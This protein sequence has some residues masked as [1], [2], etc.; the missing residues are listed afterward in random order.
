MNHTILP[1]F[2]TKVANRKRADVKTRLL[3][4]WR[5]QNMFWTERHQH[6]NHLTTTICKDKIWTGFCLKTPGFKIS[7]GLELRSL[8]T[9]G[10]NKKKLISIS[11][12][13]H[14]LN[15]TASIIITL[16]TKLRAPAVTMH[17][18]IYLFCTHIHKESLEKLANHETYLQF[19]TGYS[20]LINRLSA[21]HLR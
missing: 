9:V 4:D 17:L 1:L 13:N 6:V 16:V 21:L 2:Y 5:R 19:K 10:A 20:H 12:G 15:P 8:T 7:E 3:P 11:T 18:S 14:F